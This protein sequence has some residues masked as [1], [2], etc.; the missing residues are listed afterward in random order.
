MQDTAL[1]TQLL[2]LCSP[3]KITEVTP[4]LDNKSIT[5]RIEWSKREKGQ[6]PES[7][8]FCQVYNHREK[9]AWRHLDTMQFKT[10]LIYPVPRVNC[11]EREIKSLHVSW[12]DMKGRFTILLECF[13]ID[14]LQSANNKKKAAE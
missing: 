1:F 5:I 13:A 3:W 14:V 2:G 11:K 12:A 6:C 10:L 7:K 9:H 8:T 4:D